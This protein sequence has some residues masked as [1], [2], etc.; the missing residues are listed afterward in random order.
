MKISRSLQR[1]AALAALAA[2][3]AAT[4]TVLPVS[5]A[6]ADEVVTISGQ[7]LHEALF[8]AGD[9]SRLNQ[10]PREAVL[11]R[12]LQAMYELEPQLPVAEA[13]AEIEQ[14]R[15]DMDE[16]AASERA[17]AKKTASRAAA[18]GEAPTGPDRVSGIF[19]VRHY[20][21]MLEQEAAQAAKTEKAKRAA[22]KVV[23]ES[24]VKQADE[25]SLLA[26]SP[27]QEI[28]SGLGDYGYFSGDEVARDSFRQAAIN[29]YYA[30]AR[31][32]EWAAESGQSTTSSSIQQRVA[33]PD[34]A[35]ASGITDGIS[36]ETLTMSGQDA[37]TEADKALNGPDG[38]GVAN[39][40]A[41]RTAA[42][43]ADAEE[44]VA[45]AKTPEEKLTAEQRREQVK[46]QW[47]GHLS[48]A[49]D[50]VKTTESVLKLS[51]WIVD[52]FDP[53]AAKQIEEVG[54]VVTK[55]ANQ[56]IEIGTHVLNGVMNVVSGNWVAAAG[57]LIGG[58]MGVFGLFDDSS[59]QP[60]PD[61]VLVAL[62][63]LTV[64]IED[65]RQEMHERFDRIDL[66][67]NTGFTAMTDGLN[68]ILVAL[69]DVNADLSEVKSNL[70]NVQSSL[71][72]LEA[73]LFTSFRAVE[74]RQ[75]AQAI[76]S[77]IGYRE[78]TGAPML[79]QQFED[80]AGFF[81]TGA[82]SSAKD[83]VAMAPVAASYDAVS[84][85]HQLDENPLDMNVEFLSQ[86]AAEAGGTR[87]ASAGSLVNP[88]D[89]ALSARA[90]ELLMLENP[91]FV[92]PTW[93]RR[94]A[95]V[96]TEGVK[97]RTALAKIHAEDAASGTGSALFNSLLLEY[98]TDW[99]AVDGAVRAA[100]QPVLD[101][102][103]GGVDL[104][105]GPRQSVPAPVLANTN[106]KVG[107]GDPTRP[108]T[109]NQQL[110]LGPGLSYAD[111]VPPQV[112]VAVALR[113]GVVNMCADASYVDE[114]HDIKV[115]RVG[116]FG[117]IITTTTD[118]F[119]A[120]PNAKV[121]WDYTHTAGTPQGRWLAHAQRTWP[122]QE[123][124]KTIT[125][126]DDGGSLDP[127][128]WVT[129][130]EDTC[131]G[132]S[133]ELT[134]QQKWGSNG[135]SFDWTNDDQDIQG[136]ITGMVDGWM[137]TKQNEVYAAVKNTFTRAGGSPAQSAAAEL[138]ATKRLIQSYLEVGVP[139]D[140]LVDGEL[141]GLIAGT[142]DLIDDEGDLQGPWIDAHDN[143][144]TESINPQDVL[145]ATATARLT[146]LEGHIT[147]HI[148]GTA[149]DPVPPVEFRA[150]PLLQ[151]TIDRLALVAFVLDETTDPGCVVEPGAT[152]A[153]QAKLAKVKKK[154][155]TLKKRLKKAKV[156]K[157]AAKVAKK[158]ASKPAKKQAAKKK[159]R[160]L[161]QKVTKLKKKVRNTQTKVR[162]AKA[163]LAILSNRCR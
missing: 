92:T 23:K 71:I 120:K 122:E 75:V 14:M 83:A 123:I 117:R 97:L 142:E 21:E 57:N 89:W 153:A 114:R 147:D 50:V 39:A 90:L 59:S 148:K 48:T 82:T 158:K 154:L 110:P 99:R 96:R 19:R 6:H 127:D 108:C 107:T 1:L 33:D 24:L 113:I 129:D 54:K 67:L 62:E 133:P 12:V 40:A 109:S 30:E 41:L 45:K 5:P 134:L 17:A 124:C 76:N 130:V 139:A 55:T 52:K 27:T 80:W 128:D 163:D 102:V 136:E 138:Y 137:R 160:K 4:L 141:R 140:L 159:V 81:Y 101:T 77:A 73:R 156:A 145:N 79:L 118:T 25:K 106:L 91:E 152:A 64:Q 7:E 98:R 131:A 132:T 42:A 119:F 100:M 9:M 20:L 69:G 104:W 155:T 37:L 125:T 46:K 126:V 144:K 35:G 103:P 31:D 15:A 26:I 36:G 68:Q 85:A 47:E 94:L 146:A 78:R 38:L 115:T 43:L 162:E 2:L 49:K 72:R 28:W 61:P 93:R 149:T 135:P 34:L 116:R 8:V 60:A 32:Q 22:R 65:F 29:S 53:E 143:S 70:V 3:P 51:V 11:E 10:N 161:S 56:L 74:G 18:D 150:D 105:K 112:T 58:I 111:H 95:E 157:K 44:A 16:V 66:A 13:R 88:R 63:D 86:Y 121:R 151:T 87:L 84:I